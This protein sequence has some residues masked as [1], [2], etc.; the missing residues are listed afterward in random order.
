MSLKLDGV[1][2]DAVLDADK[3]NNGVWI[4][5]DSAK[6]NDEGE[7]PP[8]YLHGDKTK[9]QRALVRSRRCQAIKDA[10]EKRQK[11]GFVKMRVAP[12]KEKD[13]VI[14]ESSI[15][16]PEEHFAIIL[17]ALDNF[18]ADGGIQQVDPA[19]A[20]MIHEMSEYDG[21]VEQIRQACFDDTNYL[22]GPETEAGN[23][24]PPPPSMTKATA[25]TESGQASEN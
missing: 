16:P 23:A 18:G 8:M 12:K 2:K 25:P 24:S 5:L 11:A 19:D 21:I 10:E 7:Y 1:A 17:V 13:R 4:H 14:V 22:A 20:K 3:I 9:P 6:M 15:L